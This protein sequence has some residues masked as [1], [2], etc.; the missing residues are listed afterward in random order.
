MA[1]RH[2]EGVAH[3]LST[4]RSADRIAVIDAG[5]LAELGTHD[6]LVMLGGRYAALAAAWDASQ[7][8]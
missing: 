5:E 8:A 6:E 3:R 1:E 2:T 7:P 4:I